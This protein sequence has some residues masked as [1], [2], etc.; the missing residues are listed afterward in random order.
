[1]FGTS[2]PAG[3]LTIGMVVVVLIIVGFGIVRSRSDK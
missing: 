2:L 3:T 1:M